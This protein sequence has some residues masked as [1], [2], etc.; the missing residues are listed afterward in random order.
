[1][2]DNLAI[3]ERVIAEHQAIRT[4]VKLVGDALNDQEALE[5]LLKSH[6]DLIPGRVEILSEEKDRLQQTVSSLEEGLNRHFDF[7]EKVLPPLFGELLMKESPEATAAV[8][9]PHN[10]FGAKNPFVK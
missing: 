10:G 9:E 2:S 8:T 5:S 6:A 4:H 7:E 3:I 1:M